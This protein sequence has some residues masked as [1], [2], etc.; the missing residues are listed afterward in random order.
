MSVTNHTGDKSLINGNHLLFVPLCDSLMHLWIPRCFIE[1]VITSSAHDLRWLSYCPCSM[2]NRPTM[3]SSLINFPFY[4]NKYCS[5]ILNIAYCYLNNIWTL[6]D[7]TWTDYL[8]LVCFSSQLWT[9]RWEIYSNGR[10]WK[11]ALCEKWRCGAAG[12]RRRWWTMVSTQTLVE[13]VRNKT[14]SSAMITL[15][16]VWSCRLVRNLSS[17]KEGWIAAA[18]LV[19]LIGK[20]KSCQSLTSSGTWIQGE[21]C[22][23]HGH[24]RVNEYEISI[25]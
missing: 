25:H 4:Q 15:I 17:S 11:R 7:L 20:S 9:E 1:N 13:L 2:G 3:L 8:M 23:T 5:Y 12:Q 16:C 19:T 6:Q 18:N 10:L 14:Y 24:L 21:Q 22:M